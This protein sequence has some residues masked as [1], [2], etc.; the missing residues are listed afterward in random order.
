MS[1]EEREAL[2]ARIRDRAQIP[3]AILA[4]VWVAV[5]ALEVSEALPPTLGVI[6]RDLDIAIWLIFLGEFLVE[7]IIAP[8]KWR[9]LRTHWITAVSV[10]VPFLRV[11]RIVV[12]LWALRS[13]WLASIFLGASRAARRTGSVLRRR[14]FQY[15]LIIL[16][17]ALFAGAAGVYFLERDDPQSQLRTY[18]AALWWAAALLSASN[19]L[20]TRAVSLE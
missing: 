1:D 17:I 11:V 15:V 8:H 13:L 3:L 19:F 10:L 2:V 5:I 18:P 16:L 4:L 14:G 12:V 6:V 7:F 20:T 9:Y